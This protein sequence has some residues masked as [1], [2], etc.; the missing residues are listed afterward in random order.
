MALLDFNTNTCY[1][2]SVC[3]ILFR[4]QKHA[5]KTFGD[6]FVYSGFVYSGSVSINLMCIIEQ[7][8]SVVPYYILKKGHFDIRVPPRVNIVS[9]LKH[10]YN[11]KRW[12]GNRK[13]DNDKGNPVHLHFI[14]MADSGEH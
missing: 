13:C 4:V 1:I 6:S 5:V 7:G 12:S 3:D 14:C 8:Q 9:G 11:I 10:S 2:L